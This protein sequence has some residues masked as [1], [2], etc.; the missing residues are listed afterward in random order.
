MYLEIDFTVLYGIP[1]GS[2]PEYISFNIYVNDLSSLQSVD[3][4][5]GF[6]DDSVILYS[7]RPYLNK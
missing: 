4:V 7:T 2:V 1:Q 3:N 5:I 6:T